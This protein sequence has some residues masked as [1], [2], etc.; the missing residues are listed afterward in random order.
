MILLGLYKKK[1]IR[2]V[3]VKKNFID[4]LKIPSRVRGTNEEEILKDIERIG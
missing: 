4:K 1:N 2:K 3:K